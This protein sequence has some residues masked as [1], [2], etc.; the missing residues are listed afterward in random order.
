[1]ARFV[2][3]GQNTHLSSET[4]VDFGAG[5]GIAVSNVD[6]TT[7][8]SLSFSGQAEATAQ[9]GTRTLTLNSP[10]GDGTETVTTQVRITAGPS[11]TA[12]PAGSLPTSISP[13][14]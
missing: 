1:M 7:T 10:Y 5:S 6:V 2:V 11:M 9:P 3:T 13:P 8:T 4:L 12:D 14:C